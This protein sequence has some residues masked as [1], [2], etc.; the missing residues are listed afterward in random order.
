MG[1]DR[2]WNEIGN[3]WKADGK[4]LEISWKVLENLRGVEGTIGNGSNARSRRECQAGGTA[5]WFS[6]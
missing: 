2:N 6:Y 4:K 1:I 3:R 5:I